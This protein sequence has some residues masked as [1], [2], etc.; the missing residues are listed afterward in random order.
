MIKR[1]LPGEIGLALVEKG[2]HYYTHLVNN[3]RIE[4]GFHCNH[5]NV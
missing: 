1:R 3:D 4:D 2:W 5:H